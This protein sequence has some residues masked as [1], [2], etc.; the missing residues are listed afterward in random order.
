M[1]SKRVKI[2]ELKNN[3]D[4]RGYSYG[5]PSE[6]FSF[7][8]EVRDVH[9]ASILPSKVRGNH[10]HINR[11]EIIVVIYF[12]KWL[13]AWD[14]GEGTLVNFIEYQGIGSVCIEIESL[15]SHAI[16]NTGNKPVQIISVCNTP[17]EP[18]ETIKRALINDS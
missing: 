5:L 18:S 4:V 6:V 8:A 14:D 12:D 11:R 3:E 7:L 9:V 17:Y 10:Y 15:V 1:S 2:M 16:K 13:F